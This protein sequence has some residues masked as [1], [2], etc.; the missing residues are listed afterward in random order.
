M[1]CFERLYI[2]FCERTLKSDEVTENECHV[3]QTYIDGLFCVGIRSVKHLIVCIM[4]LNVYLH[5]CVIVSAS[6][7]FYLP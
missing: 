4:E 5:F 7:W 2:I 1:N 3:W 6:Y